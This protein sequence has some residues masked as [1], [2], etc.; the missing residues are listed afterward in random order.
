MLYCTA[1]PQLGNDLQL[2]ISSK[3]FVF[4]VVF[5]DKLIFLG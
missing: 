5:V 2:I 4:F 3:L 1:I